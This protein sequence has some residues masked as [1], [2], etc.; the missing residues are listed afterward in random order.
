MRGGSAFFPGYKSADSPPEQTE[1][2]KPAPPSPKA[3]P[4]KDAPQPEH[5]SKTPI[6]GPEN[7]KT[8]SGEDASTLA[9]KQES[10]QASKQASTLALPPDLIEAVRRTVKNPGKEEVLYVRIS[11]EEKDKLSDVSYTYKRQGIKTSDNEIVRVALNALLE[12]YKIN[13]EKSVLALILESLH[14]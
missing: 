9:R 13:R 2:Q 1:E 4:L 7:Q 3:S 6:S 12:E 10:L 11:K 5:V 8:Q 14:A